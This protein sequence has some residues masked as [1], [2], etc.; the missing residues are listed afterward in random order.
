MPGT[1]G[2]AIEVEVADRHQRFNSRIRRANSATA[3]SR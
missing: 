2:E 1:G 3:S